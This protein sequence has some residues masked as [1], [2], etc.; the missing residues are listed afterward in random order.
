MPLLPSGADAAAPPF[1]LVERNAAAA[2]NVPMVATN[3]ML[4]GS[5]AC[6][7]IVG[8]VLVYRDGSHLTTVASDALAEPLLARLR[9][10]GLP[11]SLDG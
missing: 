7:V 9:V 5:V 8:D 6:P 2:A 1:R 4:C 10:A 3:D 11:S